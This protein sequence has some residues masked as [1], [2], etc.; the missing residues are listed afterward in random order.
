[1]ALR[2]RRSTLGRRPS[3]GGR[4]EL[5]SPPD[6]VL[7]VDAELKSPGRDVLALVY[8]Q[9]VSGSNRRRLGTFFTPD[10]VVALMLDRAEAVLGVPDEVIDPGAGVGAFTVAARRRW[11][12]D[13]T[14][15]TA[16]DVNAVTLG[17]LAAR[18]HV[19]G[20]GPVELVHDDYL[21]WV[22]GRESGNFGS[23]LL[24]GNPPYTRHQELTAKIK[25]TAR[26]SAGSLVDSGLAGLSAYFLGS[27]LRALQDDDALCFLL[28]GS[29]TEARYGRPLRD[30]V[31]AAH[32][33]AVELHAFPASCEV[34][35]GTMVTAMLVIVGPKQRRRQRLTTH[36][37]S[38]GSDMSRTTTGTV[39]PR[40][41][42]TPADFGRWLWPQRSTR[43]GATV[44]LNTLA[45]VRRGVATGANQFFFLDDTRAGDL[46]G[47][48]LQPALRRLRHAD[49][50]VLDAESHAAIGDAGLPRWLLALW[51]EKA[52]EDDEV[53]YLLSRGKQQGV[54]LGYL[55][56]DRKDWYIVERIEPPHILLGLASKGRLR[57]VRNDIRAIP[58]NS[59]YGIYLTDIELAG[60]LVAWLN[61]SEGQLALKVVGRH[62]SNGLIKLEPRAVLRVAVPTRDRLLEACHVSCGSIRNQGRLCRERMAANALLYQLI[63][64]AGSMSPPE[65]LYVREDEHQ[66]K[67]GACVA[68]RQLMGGAGQGGFNVPGSLSTV[69]DG[70]P[71]DPAFFHAL[72]RHRAERD[73][74]WGVEEIDRTGPRW[75]VAEPRGLAVEPLLD[76]RKPGWQHGAELRQRGHPSPPSAPASPSGSL[77]LVSPKRL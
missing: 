5:Q 59:M 49:S 20:L 6:L 72:E 4:I 58:S 38:L 56:S 13:S 51:D 69:E 39:R 1:M 9:L 74:R 46:P 76:G 3:V 23:R 71:A 16:V 45:R 52:L 19:L 2:A 70:I 77:S 28:P 67:G 10:S 34:F 22:G 73:Q 32:K 18:C 35:P 53:Q 37:A 57:A 33:R 15:V 41:G 63:Q 55:T 14:R 68:C 8:E 44:D 75:M 61:G 24:L 36:Q 40:T 25:E 54:H 48:A 11:P 27:S 29:W 26:A 30:A 65:G 66:A 31:W 50:D 21:S 60:P 7:R 43:H 64:N 47:S 62:Y 42:A 17:L 12:A